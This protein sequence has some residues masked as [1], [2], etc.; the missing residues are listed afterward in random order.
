MNIVCPRIIFKYSNLSPDKIYVM[1]YGLLYKG[2]VACVVQLGAE[3][4]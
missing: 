2:V 1:I 3:K 4:V